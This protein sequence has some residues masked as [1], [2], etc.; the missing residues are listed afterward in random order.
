MG[1]V[2]PMGKPEA[3][4][5]KYLTDC[6]RAR[7]GDTR[8][9]TSPMHVGVA[10]RLLLIPFGLLWFVEVKADS[11]ES[12]PQA[13]ERKRMLKLGFRAVVV[14]GKKDVDL[15]MIEVDEMLAHRRVI[16]DALS[17]K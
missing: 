12:G 11:D 4:V 6:A 14:Y 1:S 9:F 3:T 17:F 5:E 8:K 15:L 2:Q 16:N 10:D 7:G 13:R